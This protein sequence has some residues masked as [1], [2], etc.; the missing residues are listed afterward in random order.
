MRQQR[1]ELARPRRRRARLLATAKQ[2]LADLQQELAAR[3]TELGDLQQRH[4]AAAERAAV[5]EELERRHEGLS[6]GVKE[7]LGQA[8]RPGRPVP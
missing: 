6:P 7:V 3:Q 2:E 5:L 4:S 8:G 1:E